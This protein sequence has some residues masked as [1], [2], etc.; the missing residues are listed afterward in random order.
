LLVLDDDH[1]LG[2]SLAAIE[3]QFAMFLDALA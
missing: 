1:R 2:S 3:R